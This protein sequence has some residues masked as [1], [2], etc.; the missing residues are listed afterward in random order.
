MSSGGLGD[1]SDD[2]LLSG[3]RSGREGY[4]EE[5]ARR[6]WAAIQR[7]CA[8]YLGDAD[9]AEDVTQETFVRLADGH[10]LPDG[11]VRPWLYKVARNRCLDVLR[12]RQRSPTHNRPLRTHVDH[13][14]STMGPQTRTARQER[15]EVIRAIIDQMPD[16]YRE[17]LI[18]KFYEG[19]S[20]E[21]IATAVGATEAAV[22]GRLVRA[23]EYLQE[24]LRK[25][26]GSQA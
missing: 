11:A 1:T 12:R 26:T 4:A 5:L 15:R 22:K 20:R 9:L 16:E 8:A 17:V 7:F 21:E 13:A 23:S 10:D 18:L 6:Y 19:L 25:I 3:L 14:D 2:A 24:Q